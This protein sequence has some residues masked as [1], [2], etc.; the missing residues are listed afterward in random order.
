MGD[1]YKF[2]IL[3]YE[4]LDHR[5]PMDGRVIEILAQL[6]TKVGRNADGLSMDLRLSK[7]RPNDPMV[8]YNLACSLALVGQCEE[9]VNTL[10][11]SIQMGYKDFTWM[12]K[13]P[14]LNAIRNLA[15]Y[16]KLVEEIKL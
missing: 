16:V 5:D 14:D 8:H 4:S 15:S 6:Y 12:V 9:S 3:F 1:E 7:V 10:K 13:D 2:E 11:H